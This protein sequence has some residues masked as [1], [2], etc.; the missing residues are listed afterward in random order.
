MPFDIN[1]V[2]NSSSNLQGRF[3]ISLQ[4]LTNTRGHSYKYKLAKS[5]CSHDIYKYILLTVLLIFATVYR[6]KLFLTN[7]CTHSN[8]K[9]LA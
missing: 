1:K 2:W 9:S 4:Q 8:M 5:L 7:H 3:Y 6:M